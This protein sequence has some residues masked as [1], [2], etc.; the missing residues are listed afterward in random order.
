MKPDLSSA[1]PEGRF[2]EVDTV[3]RGNEFN[4][5]VK[6]C[7]DAHPDIPMYLI[8]NVKYLDANISKLLHRVYKLDLM[9]ESG[10]D[11]LYKQTGDAKFGFGTKAYSLI[12]GWKYNML[13]N[14]V[15]H[16]DIDIAIIDVTPEWNLHHFFKPLKVSN[17][18]IY[19]AYM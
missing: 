9:K 7:H 12:S 8:T 5:A 11:I 17:L 13:P 19:H 15:L 4:V 6:S 2:G 16:F 1:M 10:L 14:E 3:G 18:A